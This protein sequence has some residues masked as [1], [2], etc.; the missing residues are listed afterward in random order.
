MCK[1]ALGTS[2]GYDL[3]ISLKD[4]SKMAKNILGVHREIWTAPEYGVEFLTTRNLCSVR[5]WKK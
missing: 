5:R 4:Q 1:K 2:L 3:Y